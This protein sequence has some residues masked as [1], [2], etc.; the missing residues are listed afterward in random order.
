[1]KLTT[2]A[3]R[4]FMQAL[5][6]TVMILSEPSYDDIVPPARERPPRP[7][8]TDFYEVLDRRIQAHLDDLGRGGLV[9]SRRIERTKVHLA[10]LCAT[11][12]A[13]RFRD[14]RPGDDL[15]MP[16]RFSDW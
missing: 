16:W 13:S 10:Y 12:L 9:S 3:V 11:L 4:I 14:A 1:M 7:T 8:G 2:A 15:P 6:E 5:S